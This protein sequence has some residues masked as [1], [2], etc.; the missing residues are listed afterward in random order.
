M[1]R[2]SAFMRWPYRATF[3]TV[4]ATM[5][6]AAAVAP[7]GAATTAKAA[8][9]AESAAGSQHTLYRIKTLGKRSNGQPKLAVATPSGL[10]PSAIESVYSLSGLAPSSGAGAGQII[11]IVDAYR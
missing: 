7:A 8:P 11:A 3:L 5:A 6:V 10:P 9:L 4:A 1:W 2:R